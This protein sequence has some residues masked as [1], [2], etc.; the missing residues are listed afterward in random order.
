VDK[1]VVAVLDE[2]A[3][4]V[5]LGEEFSFGLGR[6]SRDTNVGHET[7]TF[8]ASHSDGRSQNKINANG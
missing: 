1:K 5:V 2:K 7:P 4:N 6:V 8:A 3:P